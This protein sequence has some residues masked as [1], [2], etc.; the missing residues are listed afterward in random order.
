MSARKKGSP[1]L[2]TAFQEDHRHY[3]IDIS[4]EGRMGLNA[5]SAEGCLA[6]VVSLADGATFL[7]V[8]RYKNDE[9]GRATYRKRGPAG[10]V[11]TVETLDA[12]G[13]LIGFIEAALK[14]REATRQAREQA[15]RAARLVHLT[16]PQGHKVGY[17]PASGQ[18]FTLEGQAQPTCKECGELL[19]LE[20]LQQHHQQ[21]IDALQKALQ[22]EQEQLHLVKTFQMQ[23]KERKQS[24]KGEVPQ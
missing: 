9:I 3:T 4:R 2:P 12:S 5:S 13:A 22:A 19:S 17:D 18:F 11:T 6:T 10:Q 14:K 24:S 1:A 7:L 15:E 23:R 20:A 21:C 8:A 16:C